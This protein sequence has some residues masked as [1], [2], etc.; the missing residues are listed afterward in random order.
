RTYRYFQG[1][2]LYP[3]GYGLSYSKFEYT[4]L[5]LSGATLKAGDF[6]TADADVHNTGPR[7]GDEVVELYVS[8]PHSPTAP[9][10][11]LRGFTRIHVGAGDTEHVHFVLDARDLSE[12]D[13]N[14]DR[15]VTAGAYRI[16]VGGGQPGTAA[17]QAEAEFKIKGKRTLPD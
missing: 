5:K 7:D 8:F 17:P 13:D 12:V 14:G 11:A 6:L 16:T 2:P 3:F 1:Q 10:R 4:N 15:I 9:L